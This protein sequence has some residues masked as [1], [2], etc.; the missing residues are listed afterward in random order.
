MLH[1]HRFSLYCLLFSLLCLS[2]AAFAEGPAQPISL[3][4]LRAA[5]LQPGELSPLVDQPKSW[6]PDLP[7]FY[8]P[9]MYPD[10]EPGELGYVVTK[11]QQA[12]TADDLIES[13]MI[14][15]ATVEDASQ[16][17]RNFTADPAM[18]AVET[19]KR[20]WAGDEVRYLAEQ[21]DALFRT[22]LRF[23]TGRL[24]SRLTVISTAAFT[25]PEQMLRATAPVVKRMIRLQQGKLDAPKVSAAQAKM[26]P[27]PGGSVTGQEMATLQLPPEAWAL[28]ET[29]GTPRE[30]AGVLRA[31]GS[32]AVAVP[33]FHPA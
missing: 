1:T 10:P 25:A 30:I 3:L 33:E 19:S 21:D 20:S 24:I 29:T 13:S 28:V 9:G 11:Y 14:L 16:A 2:W 23:R 6:W 7:E 27:L 15:Y 12:D 26:L 18:Q 22:T 8:L 17:F 31:G 32:Q 4:Q 5:A